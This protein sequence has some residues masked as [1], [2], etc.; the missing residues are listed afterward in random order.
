MAFFVGPGNNLG[1]PI[2]IDKVTFVLCFASAIL[3][4]P[5]LLFVS[6]NLLCCI[7]WLVAAGP[8]PHLWHGSDERLEWCVALVPLVPLVPLVVLVIVASL[9]IIS[10]LLGEPCFQPATSRSGSTCRLDRSLA[11]T[12][13]PLFHLGLSPW[14][15]LLLLPAPTQPRSE[16]GDVMLMMSVMINECI[17]KHGCTAN[18]G[19]RGG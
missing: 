14:T 7:A 1:E 5:P 19:R 16:R 11:R 17:W 9:L 15:R 4:T 10:C 6:F 2:P 3:L 8:R 13:A 12:L 18:R